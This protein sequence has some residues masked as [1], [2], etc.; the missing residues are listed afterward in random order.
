[1][2]DPGEPNAKYHHEDAQED[3]LVLSGECILI[4]D[5]VEH[6]LRAWDFVHCP[7]GAAHVFVGAGDSPCAILMVGARRDDAKATYPPNELAA[8][9]GASVEA[10]T[11]DSSSRLCRLAQELHLRQARLA[12]GGDVT[13]SGPPTIVT[14]RGGVDDVEVMLENV[15][16]GFASYVDFAPAGWTPPR[17]TARARADARRARA[18]M[19]PW[20]LLALIDGEPAG[21]VGMTSARDRPAGG[22][23]AEGWRARRVIPG[24]VHLW[25]LFVLPQWWGTG[26]ADVLHREFIVRGESP[27]LRD[28]PP[29]HACRTR[30]RAPLL[31][32]PR[33]ALA[34]RAAQPRARSGARRVPA[35]LSRS[36]Q[37]GPYPSASRAV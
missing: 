36:S 32:A 23:S 18:T 26:V 8:R 2:L 10:E 31:R 15:R 14:R 21:H 20:T 35:R 28:R 24:M 25:Q 6:R 13:E 5:G 33:L 27:R 30:A 34:R 22:G 1:M 17:I 29:L 16:A 9:W 11:T 12:A 7:A 37:V 19:A 3:F 4:L